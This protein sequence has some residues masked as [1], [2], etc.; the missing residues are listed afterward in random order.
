MSHRKIEKEIEE[1]R[2]TFKS[3]MI[4][5]I[6]GALSFA[7]ALQWNDFITSLVN[8]YKDSITSGFFAENLW[9]LKFVS[10]LSVSFFAI[11]AVYFLSKLKE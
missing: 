9:I 3:Q 1:F 2:K 6:T 4:S 7:T 8:V 11:T 5:F 10:A